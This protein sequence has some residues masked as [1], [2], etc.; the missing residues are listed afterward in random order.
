MRKLFTLFLLGCAAVTANAQYQVQNGG[1][2][3]W[4]TVSYQLQSGE[5]KTG[6]EPVHWNSFLTGTGTLKTVAGDNQ[7][8]KVEDPRPGSEGKYSAKLFARNVLSSIYAQGNLTT[9]CI[10]M[11][12]IC[13]RKLQL[14]KC[15]R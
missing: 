4:E 15:R 8:E 2:E 6:E 9:G 10:N 13:K 1:F 7:L 14:Y 12:S 3:E 5:A 11:G